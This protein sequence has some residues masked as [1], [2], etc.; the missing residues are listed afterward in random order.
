[1]SSD[2]KNVVFNNTRLG[3]HFFLYFVRNYNDVIHVHV[4]VIL[5]TDDNNNNYYYYSCC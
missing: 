1:M 2:S 5:A 4:H 3:W